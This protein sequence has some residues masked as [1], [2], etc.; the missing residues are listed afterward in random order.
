MFL[1]EEA[2][3]QLIQTGV[4]PYVTNNNYEYTSEFNSTLSH[5][6]CSSDAFTRTFLLQEVQ[7]LSED[8][9]DFQVPV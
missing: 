4:N 5:P 2:Q 8:T 6:P 9:F 1:C 7:F 3:H